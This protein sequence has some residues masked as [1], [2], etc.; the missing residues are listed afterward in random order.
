[1]T[2]YW[3]KPEFKKQQREW[4]KKLKEEGFVDIEGG[5][6][7]NEAKLAAKGHVKSVSL[8]ALRKYL[9]P[10]SYE[11][12]LDDLLSTD[13]HL[14]Q[15]QDSHRARFYRAATHIVSEGYRQGL[16]E[17]K[18]YV[19]TMMSEGLGSPTIKRKMWEDHCFDMSER[20]INTWQKEFKKIVN[21]YLQSEESEVDI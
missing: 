18:L 12:K 20:E 1:M 8:E 15:Y 3:E 19:W 5:K 10:S 21:D 9:P 6:D 2:K 4:Y 11:V 7:E 14:V 17:K 13:H 16:P